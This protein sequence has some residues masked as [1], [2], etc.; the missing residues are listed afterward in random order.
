MGPAAAPQLIP[1]TVLSWALS[2][3][4]WL[5]GILSRVRHDLP[6]SARL[7]IDVWLSA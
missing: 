2:T 7:H 6:T 5:R 1:V 4:W 3:L